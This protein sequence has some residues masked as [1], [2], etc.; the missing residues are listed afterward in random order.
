MGVLNAFRD[1]PIGLQDGFCL[2]VSSSISIT[3]SPPNHNLALEHSDFVNSQ[4]G[5]EI[6]AGRYSVGYEPA[7]FERLFGPYRTA[8]LGVVVTPKKK[9]LIQDHSFP[10]QDPLMHSINSEIDP[11]TIKCDWGTFAQCYLLVARAPAG[12]QAVVFDVDV[13]HHRMPVAPKDRCH[14]CISWNDKVHVDHCCC[15]GCSS[16]SGIFG[17]TL[18]KRTHRS[19]GL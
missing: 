12:T 3:Y 9:R 1:V 17:R 13:A 10:R 4:I 19:F 11:D 18:Q 6:T 7:E 14:V 16:S 2:G 8:P 15:F 5:K